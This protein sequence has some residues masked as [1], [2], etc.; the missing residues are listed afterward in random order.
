MPFRAH[1]RRPAAAI[2]HRIHQHAARLR[3]VD[4]LDQRERRNVFHLAAR[5]ARRELDI[6]D[7]RI[8]RICRVELAVGLAAQLLEPRRGRLHLEISMRVTRASIGGRRRATTPTVMAAMSCL[9]MAE[10]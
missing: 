8:L 5:V 10:E 1:C 7:E 2:D 6:G 3:H 9:I 4:R